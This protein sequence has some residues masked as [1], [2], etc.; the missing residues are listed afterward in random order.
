[1]NLTPQNKIS[2]LPKPDFSSIEKKENSLSYHAKGSYKKKKSYVPESPDKKSSKFFTPNK[3][4][5]TNCSSNFSK[6]LNFATEDN[7][8]KENFLFDFSNDRT[9]KKLNFDNKPSSFRNIDINFNN[10]SNENKSLGNNLLGR[11]KEEIDNFKEINKNL[12]YTSPIKSGI[13]TPYKDHNKKENNIYYKS[14]VNSNESLK[15]NESPYN[16]HKSFTNQDKNFSGFNLEKNDEYEPAPIFL[17]SKKFSFNQMQFNEHLVQINQLANNIN[18]NNNNLNPN[19][20]NSTDLYDR[21]FSFAFSNINFNNL[22]KDEHLTRSEQICNNFT[23][24]DC[25]NLINSANNGNNK[26]TNHNNLYIQNNSYLNQCNNN[27]LD[28]ESLKTAYTNSCDSFIGNYNYFENN[29]ETIKTLEEGSFGVVYLCKE[30]SG[31]IFAVKQSKKNINHNKELK[32][33]HKMMFEFNNIKDDP[34]LMCLKPFI[35]HYNSAW[36]D[37]DNHLYVQQEYCGNGDLL[38]YLSKLENANVKLDEVFYWDLIFEMIC[39][40]F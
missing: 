8:N 9:N 40:S 7:C 35:V 33:L 10:F 19:F 34:Q 13:S 32:S 14:I 2:N 15:K 38:D 22:N 23:N 21:K 36:I 20:T 29:F 25:N 27:G 39:V 26:Y 3:P 31:E 5:I 37:T 30:K 16:N 4:L 17:N 12:M 11:K 6:K 1:M 18:D 24:T 28:F